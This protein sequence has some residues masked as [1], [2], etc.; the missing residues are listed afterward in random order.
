MAFQEFFGFVLDFMDESGVVVS[1]NGDDVIEF[2]F[3]GNVIDVFGEI[4]VD[5]IGIVWEY[6]DGWVYWVDG[7]G[8]DGSIFVFG[9]WFFSGLNVLDDEVINVGVVVFVLVGI[10][11]LSGIVMIFVNNDVVIIDFEI[12]IIIDI[13]AND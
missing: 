2:F 3:E 13:L 4:N 7:I 8:L 5:G 6:Q 12:G 10:Y 11:S 9:N 1:I